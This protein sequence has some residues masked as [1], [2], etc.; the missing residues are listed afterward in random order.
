MV[1]PEIGRKSVSVHR[2]MGSCSR[3]SERLQVR[4][5]AL[6]CFAV[7]QCLA[8]SS[9]SAQDPGTVGQFSSV[10]AQPYVATHAHLFPTGKVLYWPPTNGDNPTPWKS[11]TNTNPAGT[12]ETANLAR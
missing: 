8:V 7:A 9:A 11:S 10:T 4:L 5:L 2:P 12:Q 1:P 3:F 6:G